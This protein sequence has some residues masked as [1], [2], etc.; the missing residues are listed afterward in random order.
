M[1]QSSKYFAEYRA[2]DEFDHEAEFVE[3]NFPMSN[4]ARKKLDAEW[5]RDEKRRAEDA[6]DKRLEDAEDA[7]KL[8]NAFNQLELSKL[9][10][11]LKYYRGDNP[12]KFFALKVHIKTLS[13]KLRA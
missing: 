2:A 8:A 7:V 11:E 3:H 10:H 5:R 4:H 13:E 12:E 9:R 1:G 6:A